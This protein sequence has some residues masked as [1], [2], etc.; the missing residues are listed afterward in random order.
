MMNNEY[1]KFCFDVFKEQ[2]S[3]LENVKLRILPIN[4]MKSC[5]YVRPDFKKGNY[6]IVINSNAFKKMSVEERKIY[7]Y[8]TICHEIEHIK[9][10]ENTKKRHFF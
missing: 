7:S 6:T 3:S 9:I 8:I 1:K 2:S 5:G 4:L 10:F